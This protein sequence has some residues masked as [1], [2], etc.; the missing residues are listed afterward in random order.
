MPNI[1][2]DLP[3]EDSRQPPDVAQAAA[4]ALAAGERIVIHD[5]RMC[6]VA[7]AAE[8]TDADLITDFA[9]NARG[10][11]VVAISADRLDALGIP[12]L[13]EA[14]S[15]PSPPG[16]GISVDAIV[17]TTTGISSHDRAAT[18]RALLAEDAEGKIAMPGHVF[19]LRA[20]PG[21]VL[22]R[23]GKVEALV[24]LAELAGLQSAVTACAILD[25]DGEAQR[26]DDLAGHES[27]SSLIAISPALVRAHL[28][29][30]PS[31]AAAN[32]ATYREAMSLLACSAGGIT[33]RDASGAPR[34]MLATSFASFTD[35]PPSLLISIAH[36]SRSH[37]ALVA[38]T[39]IGVHILA[40]E[41]SPVAAVLAGKSDD[42]FSELDWAWDGDV[43]K[44]EGALAYLRC[45][46]AA[47]YE[48][49]DH[50]VLIADVESVE[51]GDGLPLVYFERT[52]GWHLEHS[53][54]R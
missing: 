26:P 5:D 10:V 12:G 45:A 48:H 13:E 50:T 9:L 3:R 52:L 11:I 47:C 32:P 22:E 19:P 23:P 38:A 37:D 49:H 4:A 29:D 42:K 31:L 1:G 17:G 6:M 39:G 30:L 21:G 15:T 46:R 36:S 44:L 54:L 35:S 14:E 27:Y 34:G 43:P 25:A 24:A 18:V 16:Y 2:D 8:S 7:A 28:R 40:R 20:A 51:L 41:Q 53:A 33:T